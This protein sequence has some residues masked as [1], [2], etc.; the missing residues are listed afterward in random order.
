MPCDFYILQTE[1]IGLA[2]CL[3][4]NGRLKNYFSPGGTH[5]AISK[6]WACDMRGYLIWPMYN[7]FTLNKLFLVYLT[8]PLERPS[9][10]ISILQ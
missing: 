1:C 9:F 10:R 2:G 3:T 6:K 5:P 7:T 8:H 4:R